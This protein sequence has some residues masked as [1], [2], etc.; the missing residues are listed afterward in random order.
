MSFI[1]P[2]E[3]IHEERNDDSFVDDTLNACNDAHLDE[4]MPY[5]KLIAMAQ[6]GAQIWER[7]LYSSGS[8]LDLKKCFWYLIY[9]QWV[10][11]CP[12]MAMN[13][14]CP[15]IIALTSGN[16][17]NYLVIPRLEAWEARRTLGVRPAPDGNYRKE[18][19]FLL[20]KANQYTLRLSTS[21]L[22]EMDTFIFHR[23][24]YIPSMM[25]SL[26]V[27]TI[28]VA[29][30]N[31]IQRRAIQAILNKLGVSKSFPRWVAFGP[32][33]LCGM[34]LMD[35]SVEQGIRRVQHFTDHLFSRDSVGNLILIV[36]RSLQL[37]SGERVPYIMECWL[38]LIRDF[39][40]RSKI[41]IKVASARLV[42]MSREHDCHVMDAIRQLEI[43]DDQQLFD[44]NAVRMYL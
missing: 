28:D 36:L 20:F 40:S 27:T 4:P 44:I 7:L 2:W 23:S 1:D 22:S 11:G 26:P 24:T 16:I 32:K 37:E 31:K 29:I 25:Y 14:S 34:A 10:N 41:T 39:I 42:Q 18:A 3:D 6:P 35:M 9:W 12:Q 43:Y 38:T 8:A 30:L 13:L 19:E 15:G 33:D 5:A 17:P 21:H